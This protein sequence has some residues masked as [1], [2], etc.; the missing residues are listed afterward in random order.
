MNDSAMRFKTR[1]KTERA[2]AEHVGLRQALYFSCK[3]SRFERLI[4]ASM[5]WNRSS[6]GNAQVGGSPPTLVA[7]WLACASNVDQSCMAVSILDERDVAIPPPG[8]RLAPAGTPPTPSFGC[9]FSTACR[10]SLAFAALC[11]PC[12]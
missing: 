5:R 9:T 10:A 4:C 7:A 2:C 3:M 8:L 12:R 11:M 1:M 6:G